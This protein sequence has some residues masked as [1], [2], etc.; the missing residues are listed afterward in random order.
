MIDFLHFCAVVVG[1]STLWVWCSFLFSVSVY[2][3]R[4]VWKMGEMTAILH[5]CNMNGLNITFD[6]NGEATKD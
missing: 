1:I 4:I 3:L 5:F 2:M 6:E